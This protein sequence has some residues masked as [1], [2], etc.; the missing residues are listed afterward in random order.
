MG[1]LELEQTVMYSTTLYSLCFSTEREKDAKEEMFIHI[2]T[3][4]PGKMG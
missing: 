3:S 1:W 4:S 2:S